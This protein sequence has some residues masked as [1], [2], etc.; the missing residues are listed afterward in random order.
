[1]RLGCVGVGVPVKSL[2]LAIVISKNV[3]KKCDVV[4]V[5]GSVM[6]IVLALNVFSCSV[7]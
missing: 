2:A 6:S 5:G 3:I 4:R 7:S 1:M